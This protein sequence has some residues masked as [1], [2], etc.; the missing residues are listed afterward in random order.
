MRTAEISTQPE[1]ERGIEREE[2]K[3]EQ[4]GSELSTINPFPLKDSLRF[5][6]Y[7]SH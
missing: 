6:G 1:K 5:R 2:M 4:E 7:Y 3:K